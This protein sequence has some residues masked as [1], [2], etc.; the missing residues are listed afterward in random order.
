MG[1]DDQVMKVSVYIVILA[2]FWI[3]F[4][5]GVKSIGDAFSAFSSVSEHWGVELVV[6]LDY[7]ESQV[8][9]T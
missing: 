2:L 4:D 1:I 6:G 5:L 3:H 9:A 8:Q 7:L